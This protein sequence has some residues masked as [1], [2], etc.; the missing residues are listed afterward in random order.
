[1]ANSPGVC[2]PATAALAGRCVHNLRRN[3]ANRTQVFKAELAL[4]EAQQFSDADA[5]AAAATRA[6]GGGGGSGGGGCGGGGGGDGDG[7]GDGGG[8]L[9]SRR[10]RAAY[11]ASVRQ[12]LRSCLAGTAKPQPNLRPRRGGGQGGG[13]GSGSGCGGGF[14]GS[15]SDSGCGNT[16]GCGCG[17]RGSSAG[18]CASGGGGDGFG[19]DDGFGDGDSDSD[20]DVL[21]LGRGR[22]GSASVPAWACDSNLRAAVTEQ[23]QSGRTLSFAEGGKTCDLSQVFGRHPVRGENDEDWFGGGGGGAG[24]APDPGC[25]FAEPGAEPQ[26]GA[27]PRASSFA[28]PHYH[29]A[30]DAAVPFP[31]EESRWDPNVH[32]MRQLARAAGNADGGGGGGGGGDDDDDGDDDDEGA[33][34]A[35]VC[36]FPVSL[37]SRYSLGDDSAQLD[38]SVPAAARRSSELRR[39]HSAPDDGPAARRLSVVTSRAVELALQSSSAAG[40]SA[41]SSLGGGMS[42]SLLGRPSARLRRPLAQ[43]ALP[44]PQSQ[45]Q[46]QSQS[47]LSFGSSSHAHGEENQLNR[48]A[49]RGHGRRTEAEEM[50][51]VFNGT[52]KGEG[53][54]RRSRGSSLG[55]P[56]HKNLYGPHVYEAGVLRGKLRRRS[57]VVTGARSGG[58]VRSGS[59]AKAKAKAGQEAGQETAAEARFQAAKAGSG[60]GCRD[61]RTLARRSS[62]PGGRGGEAQAGDAGQAGAAAEGGGRAPPLVHYYVHRLL[63]QVIGCRQ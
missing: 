19:G 9:P 25:W 21:R 40:Q 58:D 8:G 16:S 55:G 7:D 22:S 32:E 5:R 52:E 48:R 15:G 34:S 53:S 11:R 30:A 26:P 33:R 43:L 6:W 61:G 62:A 37:G 49:S 41:S 28:M 46:S 59:G 29:P 14:R 45:S 56:T 35:Y 42:S 18:R 50:E 60:G 10:A 13:G 1:M 63:H 2:Y 3:F 39:R 31:V 23:Q 17:G 20:G 54:K 44:Q 47:R 51:P 38:A 36:H 12:G 27:A 57:D 24:P 4:R